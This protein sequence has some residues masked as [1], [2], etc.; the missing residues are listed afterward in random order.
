MRRLLGLL[1]LTAPQT[2]AMEATHTAS[3]TVRADPT[4]PGVVT[5]DAGDGARRFT[6]LPDGELRT[7]F[8]L[9]G[10]TLF[11]QGQA[12]LLTLDAPDG[13]VSLE[14]ETPL[15]LPGLQ[16]VSPE[17]AANQVR[18]HC[19]AGAVLLEYGHDVEH[20]QGPARP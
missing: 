16:R 20:P 14:A 9:R 2:H 19:Q 8:E 15:T 12:I 5:L 6:C 3:V 7:R 18:L 11:V 4:T 10:Q 17:V 1:L 13:H